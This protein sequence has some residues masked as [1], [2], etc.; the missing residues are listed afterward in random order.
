MRV[1]DS[2]VSLI[3]VVIF[4]FFSRLFGGFFFLSS[5]WLHAMSPFAKMIVDFSP[6]FS[7]FPENFLKIMIDVRKKRETRR[8]CPNDNMRWV[9]SGR[10]LYHL[11]LSCVYVCVR[12]FLVG[13][14]VCRA[15][16]EIRRREQFLQKFFQHFYSFC[17]C[18]VFVLFFSVFF[19]MKHFLCIRDSFSVCLFV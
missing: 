1:F 8:S 7:F 18:C 12:W 13:S 9:E 19:P 11:L 5:F 4:F 3:V 2:I 6:F 10:D 16:K 15:K 14:F 17:C